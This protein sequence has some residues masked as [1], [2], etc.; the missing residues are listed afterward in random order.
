MAAPGA[1]RS[2]PACEARRREA[3]RGR[4]LRRP[5]GRRD[6]G[7]AAVARGRLPRRSAPRRPAAV[8]EEVAI[9][10]ALAIVYLLVI[11]AVCAV[12]HRALPSKSFLAAVALPL[13]ALVVALASPSRR[14]PR[15]RPSRTSR[16]GS[17]AGGSSAS[18][19]WERTS[20]CA[21]KAGSRF[22]AT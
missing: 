15:A 18:K 19:P 14:P 6:G 1:R 21:S 20:S 12:R 22:A 17:T 7:H 4:A 16:S 13:A 2:R 9:F 11:V 8:T 3:A 5:S 10:G